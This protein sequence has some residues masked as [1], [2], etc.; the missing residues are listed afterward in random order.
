MCFVLVERR[1]MP[2][3]VRFSSVV[4]RNSVIATVL[5]PAGT[6]VATPRVEDP[7]T[8]SAPARRAVAGTCG[9]VARPRGGAPRRAAPG[10]R[11]PGGAVAGPGGA[12][13]RGATVA[14]STLGGV[15]TPVVFDPGVVTTDAADVRDS[16]NP[17]RSV[18]DTVTR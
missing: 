17:A 9:A 5:A 12:A 13:A 14:A 11:T 7:V 6:A 10:A 18:N 16:L 3:D 4:T 2:A 8:R 1:V 15:L